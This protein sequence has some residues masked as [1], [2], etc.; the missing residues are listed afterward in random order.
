MPSEPTLQAIRYQGIVCASLLL[1]RPLS[2]YYLTYITDEAPF[3]AVVEMS[4]LVDRQHFGGRSLVYLPRYC[5]R[6]TTRLR[7]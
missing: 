1:E 5:D 2:P 6:R 7:A 3:T 4:A